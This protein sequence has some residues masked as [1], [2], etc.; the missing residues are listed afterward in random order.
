MIAN[1]AKLVVRLSQ[2]EKRDIKTL[3]ASQGLTLRQA[4]LQAF[5]AWAA[6]L[7]SRAPADDSARGTP[8]G[9]DSR[10][11]GQPA[12]AATPKPG[13]QPAHR[14]PS[15]TPASGPIPN[16]GADSRAWLSRAAQLDWSKCPAAEFLRGETGSIWVVRGTS[17][18][19]AHV[20]QSVADGHPVE[21]IAKVFE[22]TLPQLIAILQFA[23]EGAAPASAGR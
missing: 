12:R 8:A 6:Q 4:I 20:L 13:Q 16:P 5:Q 18:P 14:R 11:L 2:A 7:P 1:E 19:L 23:A 21:K 9:P 22:T 10:R 17:A 3:A 15:S